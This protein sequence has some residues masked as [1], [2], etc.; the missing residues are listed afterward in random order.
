MCLVFAR[1]FVIREAFPAAAH[2]DLPKPP[3]IAVL[4]LS[5]VEAECLFV[6]IAE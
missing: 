4:I 6:Q 5:F 1:Y 3:T 2:D